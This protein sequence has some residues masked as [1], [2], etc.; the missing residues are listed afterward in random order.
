MS[1]SGRL[2]IEQEQ[3][4]TSDDYHFSFHGSHYQLPAVAQEG[5]GPLESLSHS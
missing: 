2:F 1:I 5:V 4:D 3:L